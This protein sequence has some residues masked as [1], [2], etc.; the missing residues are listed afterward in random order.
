MK[1]DVNID[2]LSR[3]LERPTEQE[4]GDVL[5]GDIIATPRVRGRRIVCAF[6]GDYELNLHIDGRSVLRKPETFD[7][8]AVIFFCRRIPA[9][10]AALGTDHAL[11]VDEL[12]NTQYCATDLYDVRSDRYLSSEA[13]LQNISRVDIAIAP[14]IFLGAVSHE[15]ELRRRFSSLTALGELIELRQELGGGVNARAYY[16][17]G[18]QNAV[19]RERA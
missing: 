14:F 2:Q 6:Y 1:A 9:L 11:V 13:L 18:V 12:T 4:L 10:F 7:I 15:G 17:R 3:V 8:D 16:T 5:G 19:L